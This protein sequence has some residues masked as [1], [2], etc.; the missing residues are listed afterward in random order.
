MAATAMPQIKNVVFLMLENRSLDNVLGW[1]YRGGSDQ[2][3]NVY[4][5][6]S[7]PSFD[8]LATG[9]YTNPAYVINGGVKS[10]NVTAVPD[11]SGDRVPAYDPYE[12]LRIEGEWHGVMNQIFG[13]QDKI[14]RL[15]TPND[16]SRMLG[17]LQD[18]YARYMAQ[19]QGLDILWAFTPAQ[20]PTINALARQYAV[21]DRWFCSVPSQTNPNRAYSLCG[22][23]LG[24]ESNANALADEHFD[25]TT[26]FNGL[27]GAGKSW[28]LYF[29]DVWK[30]GL[31]YTEYTFPWIS[32]VR[33]NG[34][35]GT[36]DQFF[37]R[38]A[39]GTLPDFTYLEPTWGYG[40][41]P[42]YKQGTDLHPPTHVTPGDDFVGQVYRAIRNGPQW[43]QTLF[44][45][46][47]DEHGGT[48]DH[49]APPWGATNPD[50]LDGPSG[51]AFNLFGVRVPT[52]LISPFVAPNTVFRSP[53]TTPFDHTSFIKS[54]LLWAGVD[55][56]SVSMGNRMPLAP[57][58]DGVLS[59]QPVNNAIV[60]AAA[61]ARATPA[62]A[63]SNQP[64][65]A[66]FEGIGAVAT[67][68]ILMTCN[69]LAAIEAAVAAYR[70]DPEGFEA[71]LTPTSR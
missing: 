34:E 16:P 42:F 51:F 50:G 56:A 12:E 11:G 13:T 27:V 44:I 15:P 39:A 10:Y 41:G 23:S 24:H 64:L 30:N 60:P 18:Y 55:P 59:S 47:F 22:T 8:G 31:S 1:V 19:W 65:N 21:S 7:S 48:Y 26:V 45:V 20:L 4:P 69:D 49:V 32:K 52:I 71:T 36:I 57:S 38:A 63:T 58:F 5:A 40:K 66:L 67:R 61:P 2:P 35:T 29:T 46:T 68:S 17:F 33:S 28:G 43:G 54:L 3:K 9:T 14:T 6:S 62:Q 70:H 25:V 53:D 37:T